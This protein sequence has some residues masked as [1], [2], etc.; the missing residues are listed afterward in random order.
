MYEGTWNDLAITVVAPVAQH[1]VRRGRRNALPPIEVILEIAQ[2]VEPASLAGAYLRDLRARVTASSLS[3]PDEGR[4][5]RVL[6]GFEER[7]SDAIVPFGAWHGDFGPWNMSRSEGG[8]F[9]LGL[10]AMLSV[11]SRSD[12]T[13]SISGSR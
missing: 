11:S 13:S 3:D 6:A 9:D 4:V 1:V 2:Q 10:G 8:L 7:V 12:S 5:D